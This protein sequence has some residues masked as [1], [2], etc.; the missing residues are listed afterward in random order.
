MHVSFNLLKSPTITWSNA[1]YLFPNTIQ[2]MK[3][4][5]L[6]KNEHS[7]TCR[8]SCQFIMFLSLD[9]RL[10][11]QVSLLKIKHYTYSY[12][13]LKFSSLQQNNTSN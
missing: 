8:N 9:N 4:P 11:Q 5:H 12:M 3:P 7:R 1:N 2:P 10:E 13:F 6:V